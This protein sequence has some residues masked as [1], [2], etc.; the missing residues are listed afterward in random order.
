M[1]PSSFGLY[2]IGLQT[3]MKRYFSHTPTFL[4]KDDRIKDDKDIKSMLSEIY[5]DFEEIG[6]KKDG[7]DDKKVTLTNMD[8][9]K[10]GEVI[11]TGVEE[12]NQ[13]KALED[14]L[15]EIYAEEE[16]EAVGGQSGPGWINYSSHGY[17]RRL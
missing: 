5:S 13:R 10:D 11:K 2:S 1:N 17:A 4:S 14:L 3:D 6:V 9:L 7:T 12:K 15:D 8:D 16:K